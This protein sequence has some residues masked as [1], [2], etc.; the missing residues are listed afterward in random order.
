M[1]GEVLGYVLI[2]NPALEFIDEFLVNIMPANSRMRRYM[3]SLERELF[4][5]HK[6]M[7]S[8]DDVQKN[9]LMLQAR[10]VM[11][12]RSLRIYEDPALRDMAMQLELPRPS[13]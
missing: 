3:D 4:L 9:E 13:E 11:I 8:D 5:L 6:S 1:W 2:M 10:E 7:E 12:A